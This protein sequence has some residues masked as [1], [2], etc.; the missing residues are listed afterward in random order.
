MPSDFSLEI[1][2]LNENDTTTVNSEPSKI[3][4]FSSRNNTTTVQ[5]PGMLQEATTPIVGFVQMGMEWT[6]GTMN[7]FVQLIRDAISEHKQC[8]EFFEVVEKESEV[9]SRKFAKIDK[10]QTKM[11]SDLQC[12]SERLESIKE[13][14]RRREELLRSS[15][16]E[17]E[18]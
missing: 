2:T 7:S 8:D 5:Q 12:I 11:K 14:R 13:S 10:S 18:R 9:M 17:E 16:E 3:S 6:T 1:D 4:A 15:V